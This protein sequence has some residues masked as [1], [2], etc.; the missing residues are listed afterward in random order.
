MGQPSPYNGFTNKLTN[1]MEKEFR[2]WS[3]SANR[4]FVSND[5]V[6]DDQNHE[7]LV[8]LTLDGEPRVVNA[9][10]LRCGEG[11]SLG[12]RGWSDAPWQLDKEV[13]VMQFTGLK[14]KNGKKIYKGD[15]V[16]LQEGLAEIFSEKDVGVVSFVNGGFYVG[17]T[18]IGHLTDTEYILR[19]EVIGNK[20]E[21]PELLP[22]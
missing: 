7:T 18:F 3:K 8:F 11:Q 1:Y 20:F 14:D 22:S 5:S 15:I 16:K 13:E 9:E 2:I 4:M 12:M 17:E 6:P 10:K 21:N 19:G